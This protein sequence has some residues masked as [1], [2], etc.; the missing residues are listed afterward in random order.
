MTIS[1]IK[2]S[3]FLNGGN[4]ENDNT[5]VGLKSGQNTYFNNPWT[6]LPSGSTGERPAIDPTMYY[7]LRFNTQI[8]Q[9]EY[10]DAIAGIWEQLQETAD[11]FAWEVVTTSPKQMFPNTGYIANSASQIVFVLPT[12]SEVTTQIRVVGQG[13]G[14]WSIT[15]GAGQS[16]HVGPG[17]TTVGAAG[18]VDSTSHTDTVHLINITEDLEWTT[19]DPPQS[20]G[21]DV[22]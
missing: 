3:E 10:Y 6:F 11:E 2:F 16:I 5:T 9:Y 19:V 12:T 21:L 8:R 20:L 13:A 22:F 7:R 15:Q 17:V 1:T 4:L 14:G 18:H